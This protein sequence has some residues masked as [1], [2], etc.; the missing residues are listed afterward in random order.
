MSNGQEPGTEDGYLAQRRG[1]AEKC[2]CDSSAI[3]APLRETELNVGRLDNI[4]INATDCNQ[5]QPICGFFRYGIGPTLP[6]SCTLLR[7]RH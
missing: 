3:P 1:G 5:M 6:E 2:I 4:M 7:N